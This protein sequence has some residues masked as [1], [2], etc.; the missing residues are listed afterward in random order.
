MTLVLGVDPGFSGAFAW[1]DYR[2]AGDYEITRI[3]DM[4]VVSKTV[5]RGQRA[6]L[7]IE[8]VHSLLSQATVKGCALVV[9]EDPGARPAQA[10]AM[11]FGFGLGILHDAIWVQKLRLETIVPTK[12]KRELRVPKDK[13]EA[14]QRADELFPAH[15]ALFRGPRGGLLDGRAEAAIIAL[16]GAKFLL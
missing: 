10:G 7:D 13:T 15:R 1:L 8:G 3:E 9:I 14:V 2:A 4:P 12:W 5:G 6:R 16:Y 11:A